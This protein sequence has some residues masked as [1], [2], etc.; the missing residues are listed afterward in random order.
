MY[1]LLFLNINSKL[2][3]RIQLKFLYLPCILQPCSADLVL[4]SL[5]YPWR[6]WIINRQSCSPRVEIIIM[7]FAI[8]VLFMS[9][10]C[11]FRSLGLLMWY[12]VC[13]GSRMLL[14]A[15]IFGRGGVRDSLELPAVGSFKL[16]FV[17]EEHKFIIENRC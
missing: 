1:I 9:F 14:A 7:S 2:H 13:M 5:V 16:P 12:G 8:C 17:F 3:R 6:F 10:N 4:G 11:S 15:C